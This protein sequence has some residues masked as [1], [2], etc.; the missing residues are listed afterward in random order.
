MSSSLKFTTRS[1]SGIGSEVKGKTLRSY[2]KFDDYVEEY[3]KANIQAFWCTVQRLCPRVRRIM[4]TK[5]DETSLY[6]TSPDDMGGTLLGD[7]DAMMTMAQFC[8]QGLDV[9]F[10]TTEPAKDAVVHRRKRG[11]IVSSLGLVRERSQ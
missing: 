3:R 1:Q 11:L 4:F 8:P 9:F 5:D 10:Y 6:G 2:E 7:M